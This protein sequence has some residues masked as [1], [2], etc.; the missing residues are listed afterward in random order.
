MSKYDL[1]VGDPSSLRQMPVHHHDKLKIVKIVG[2]CPQKSLVELT[3]HILECATSL[4]FLILDTI[5]VYYRCSGDI[6]GRKCTTLNRAS[7]SEAYKSIVVVKLY[8]EE[9]VPS[10]VRL[11]VLEPCKRCHLLCK[12]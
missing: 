8:I 5:N 6:S 11:A 3:R 12:I 2:F 9:K 1:V 10:T 4:K 7:V